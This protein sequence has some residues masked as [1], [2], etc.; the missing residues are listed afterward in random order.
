[1]PDPTTRELRALIAHR[2]RLGRLPTMGR[3]GPPASALN[4]RVALGPS[5]WAR[6]GLAQLRAL[7]LPPHTANRR[8]D[9]LEL[10]TWLTTH[11][12]QLDA[13]IA[14]AARPPTPA[15]G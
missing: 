11:I 15:P 1:M 4:R 2:V 8:A 9:S 10:L 6:R 12:D 3:D 7:S 14:E 5:L 13:Q